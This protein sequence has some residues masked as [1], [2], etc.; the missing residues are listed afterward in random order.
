M[1]ALLF[2]NPT[3]KMTSLCTRYKFFPLALGTQGP[4]LLSL[5]TTVN[6][7]LGIPTEDWCKRP[8]K[9]PTPHTFVYINAST[10]Q[11]FFLPLPFSTESILEVVSY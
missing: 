8:Q 10:E 11:L 6:N 1:E 3:F 9:L 7:F 5:L 2:L 4:V